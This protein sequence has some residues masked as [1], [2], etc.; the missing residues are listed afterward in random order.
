MCINE[1]LQSIGIRYGYVSILEYTGFV[2]S[3]QRGISAKI[4]KLAEDMAAL[5]NL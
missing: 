2:S 5:A 1:Y 4:L 3:I